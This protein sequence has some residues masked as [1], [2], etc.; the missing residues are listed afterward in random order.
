M[1]QPNGGD[2]ARDQHGVASNVTVTFAQ[3]PSR[4]PAMPMPVPQVGEL[5]G[6]AF[7][8]AVLEF[9][10]EAQG[11]SSAGLRP[12]FD[13]PGSVDAWQGFPHHHHHHHDSI[14]D[15]RSPH[16]LVEPKCELDLMD[17]APLGLSLSSL[18]SWLVRKTP[19][20]PAPPKITEG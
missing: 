20:P 4:V 6:E 19:L 8:G 18:P 17:P 3:S 10:A 5:T 14:G 16:G 11:S 2:L 9:L 15:D 1:L 12:A 7:D 13:P